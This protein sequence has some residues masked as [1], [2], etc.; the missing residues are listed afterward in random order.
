MA[1]Q[2]D[3]SPYR[4]SVELLLKLH[5]L[6]RDGRGET[7]EADAIRESSEGPWWQINEE[8]KQR[9]RCLSANLSIREPDSTI[10]DP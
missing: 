10:P 5:L 4:Q 1:T 2:P 3:D 7:D 8:E 9:L 6:T